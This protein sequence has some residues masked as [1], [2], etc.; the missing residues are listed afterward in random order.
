MTVESHA[1]ELGHP[2]PKTYAKIAVILTLV[3]ILELWVFYIEAMQPFLVPVLSVLSAGKFA[4]VVMFYM[5]LKFDH[6]AFTR[7]ILLGLFLALSII[8]ALLALFFIAH[9]FSATG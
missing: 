7:L 3:T 9:P 5:H 8:L 2:T 1:V 6:S 4:L